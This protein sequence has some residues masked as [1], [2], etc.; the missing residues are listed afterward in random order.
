MVGLPERDWM[1]ASLAGRALPDQ[2]AVHSTMSYHKITPSS[3][4]EM[5][6]TPS[7]MDGENGQPTPN[8]AK[9]R[10]SRHRV[11]EQHDGQPGCGTGG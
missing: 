11:L 3:A 4:D 2:Q 10:P 1:A 7:Q 6:P 8:S 9:A 5:V